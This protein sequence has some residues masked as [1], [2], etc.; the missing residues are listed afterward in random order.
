MRVNRIG[1]S[2]CE[3][4]AYA[5]CAGGRVVTGRG[6]NP[7]ATVALV[8]SDASAWGEKSFAFF[9]WPVALTVDLATHVGAY[10]KEDI[11]IMSMYEATGR[12]RPCDKILERIAAVVGERERVS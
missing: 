10:I 8:V 2:K 12:G 4:M 5:A 7:V 6:L 3:R 11:V 1:L 9:G